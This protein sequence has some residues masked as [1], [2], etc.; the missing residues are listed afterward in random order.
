VSSGTTAL[1]VA[2]LAVKEEIRA[3]RIECEWSVAMPTMTFAAVANSARLAG[4]AP[5]YCGHD[6]ESWQVPFS[7]WDR[8]YGVA[9]WMPAPCYG[10]SAGHVPRREYR[11]DYVISDAAESFG[12][13]GACLMGDIACVSFFANKI[14]TS[15]GEGGACLTDD[16]ALLN[17][18]KLIANHGIS[19]KDYLASSTGLNGRMT[20]IQAAVLCSQLDN[21]D[22]FLASRHA[23][24][25]RLRGHAL[26]AGWRVPTQDSRM[27]PW[28]FAGIPPNRSRVVSRCDELGIEHRM[29][30]PC[31]HQRTPQTMAQASWKYLDNAA[32]IS[33]SGICLPLFSDMADWE[34]EGVLDVIRA[35]GGDE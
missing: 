10:G 21:L 20:D 5:I 16:E 18:M 29:L 31:A 30:F 27:A 19:G 34:I 28:I 7:E 3:Q 11:G 23:V 32:R 24:L 9:V 35:G 15:G 1:L 33:A 2:L 6:A 17:R 4:A 26:E 12:A 22:D 13:T 8:G 14:V 25:H